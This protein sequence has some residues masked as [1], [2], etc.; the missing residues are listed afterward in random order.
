[1]MK[2]MAIIDLIRDEIYYPTDELDLSFK[3]DA[4]M[5]LYC[6][7]YNINVYSCN[8]NK[9]YFIKEREGE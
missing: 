5:E 8:Y 1:M 7:V 6:G 4:M 3:L 2:Y 9:V